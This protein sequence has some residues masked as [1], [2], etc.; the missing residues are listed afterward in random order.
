[1]RVVLYDP[2]Q[3]LQFIS[4]PAANYQYYSH[5]NNPSDLVQICDLLYLDGGALVLEPQGFH[6]HVEVLVFTLVVGYY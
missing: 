2:D 4:L 5:S 1:M 3:I 6:Q